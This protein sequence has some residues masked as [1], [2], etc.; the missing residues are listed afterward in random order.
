[1]S[2]TLSICC[3]NVKISS[4]LCRDV[5]EYTRRNPS[6]VRM[7]CSLIAEYSSWPAVSSTS[8]KATSSSMTHCFRY[9]SVTTKVSRS[10]H[11]RVENGCRT[12][13]RRIVLI[14]EMALDELYGQT[15]LP[16]PTASHDHELIFPE[17]LQQRWVSI[18]G[19]RAKSCMSRR[20]VARSLWKPCCRK[21][22]SFD[23]AHC[24]KRADLLS[25]AGPRMSVLTTARR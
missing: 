2:F 20:R 24:D 22:L 16:Y 13:Y 1:L 8:S 11:P 14:D 21:S 4:K 12:F 23:I 18:H 25:I 7:Y 19:S 10:P 17:K 6:P 15:G 3:W 9:E 5:I